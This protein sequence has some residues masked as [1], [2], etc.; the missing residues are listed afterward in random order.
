MNGGGMLVY[1]AAEQIR[2]FSGREPDAAR[3]LEHFHHLAAGLVLS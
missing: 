3:M 1:Q 2:L